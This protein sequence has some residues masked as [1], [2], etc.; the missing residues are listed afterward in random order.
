MG[1]MM[2]NGVGTAT[3]G[4]R[5]VVVSP[6]GLIRPVCKAVRK[7]QTLSKKHTSQIAEDGDIIFG[8]RWNP[9]HFYVQKVYGEQVYDVD[10]NVL[11]NED[12]TE[13]KVLNTFPRQLMDWLSYSPH[14]ASYL[15][16]G[17]GWH[18]GMTTHDHTK[19]NNLFKLF[20]SFDP[21][22]LSKLWIEAKVTPYFHIPFDWEL[23]DNMPTHMEAEVYN[24]RTSL[25]KV[26][27]WDQWVLWRED[28]RIDLFT[29]PASKEIISG[30][31]PTVIP[32]E[33][34][35]PPLAMPDDVIKAIRV[36]H[37][38]MRD[39]NGNSFGCKWTLYIYR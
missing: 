6:T 1:I 14:S 37:G 23:A 29:P 38:S 15:P 39:P 36:T 34:H 2:K 20:D 10:I 31:L 19:Q 17:C 30:T 5:Q 22:W 9:F 32:E 26:H 28:G 11:K 4:W 3:N 16:D 27:Q 24:H 8:V 7:G 18:D 13:K 35:R 12:S 25:C 33:I 21:D